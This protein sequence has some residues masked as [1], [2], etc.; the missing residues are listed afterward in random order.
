MNYLFTADTFMIFRIFV[1][2]LMMVNNDYCIILYS[3]FKFLVVTSFLIMIL[4]N[5]YIV[6]SLANIFMSLTTFA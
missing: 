4:S 1:S 2:S 6:S 3:F 5:P